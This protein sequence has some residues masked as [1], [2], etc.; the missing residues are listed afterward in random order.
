ME[1]AGLIMQNR[2]Y[3]WIFPSHLWQLNRSG[4]NTISHPSKQTIFKFPWKPWTPVQRKVVKGENVLPVFLPFPLFSLWST[5]KR[6]MYNSFSAVPYF[7]FHS[8]CTSRPGDISLVWSSIGY[9][10]DF[11]V[12]WVKFKYFQ[13]PSSHY[14][15]YRFIFQ[16]RRA[17]KNPARN[18][19]YSGQA[20]SI[21][22]WKL[23][24]IL[25]QD[26]RDGTIQ[27]PESV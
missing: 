13:V 18:S 12:Q 3:M 22:D 8:A 15:N 5:Q 11:E 26:L 14:Y 6:F 23:Q 9:P 20:S 16:A 21:T 25:P 4:I 19:K 10:D 17:W 2:N 27:S 7:F 24:D 1:V